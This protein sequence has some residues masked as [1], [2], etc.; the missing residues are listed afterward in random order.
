MAEEAAAP[1][2]AAGTEAAP[3]PGKMTM[4]VGVDESEHSFYALQWALQHFFP[5]PPQ[6]QQYRLVVVTAKPSAAS[7]VGLAGPGAAD[8]LPYV[9]ADLKK[10]ALRVIDKAKALCAQVSDAVF[11]A[12]EGD[13]RSV[14]CEAVERHHAEM[15]VVGSHGYGA[16]KR[17]V[18]GSVSDYCAHHAHCTV[19]IVKKPKHHKH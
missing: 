16:I 14:L 10:T 5:P 8:V 6:P 17:A 9:E 3:P 4:V 19:M 1:A 18:L 2:V 13:A 11:E 15:L 7:A 12:V